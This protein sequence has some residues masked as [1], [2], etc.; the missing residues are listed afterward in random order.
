MLSPIGS[1]SETLEFDG[2]SLG[3][4]QVDGPLTLEIKPLTVFIGPQGSGKSL[5]SQL[6]YFLRNAPFLVSKYATASNP[7]DAV[8]EIVEG[9][10]TGRLKGR[11]LSSFV[12]KGTACVSYKQR[13]DQSEE[14][15]RA[16][17]IRATNAIA[18]LKRE[19]N[20]YSEVEKLIQ[21]RFNLPSSQRKIKSQALFIPA[22]RTFFS[23]FMNADSRMLSSDALP[24]TM[25]EFS[26]ILAQ[27]RDTYTKWKEFPAS[28][29]QE[30]REIEQ[31][32]EKPLRGHV[33]YE[34][35]GPLSG[36]WQWVPQDSGQ[37]IQ[38]EMASSGQMDA[39]PFVFS[40]ETVFD[41]PEAE[42]P[43]FLHIEEPEAH[44]HPTAQVAMVHLL[45]YLVNKGFRVVITTHS[46]TIL[47]AINNLT[48]AYQVLSDQTYPDMP[49]PKI[50]LD[51]DWIGAYL[52][53]EKGIERILYSTDEIRQ[54][55]EGRLGEVAGDLQT[56]FNRIMAHGVYPN[57]EN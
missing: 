18:P 15:S 43:Q 4:I 9:L 57:E 44:L 36:T 23:R 35:A 5:A 50:R 7:D 2:S 19:G 24:L 14:I 32:V 25:V 21:D 17:S 52:F 37:S 46:L 42:R 30:F 53:G 48:A 51:P 45:A 41:M 28:T 33:R 10:R 49:D 22:E 20:F 3:P 39:W 29:P 56:E 34:K 16:I 31:L 1:F 13:S 6:L 38:I 8:R 11:N 26:D 12:S 40:V 55:D 27:G 54:I 47:Y